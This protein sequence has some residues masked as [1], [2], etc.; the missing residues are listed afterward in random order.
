MFVSLSRLPCATFLV[1]SLPI[2]VA[3]AALAQ[4]PGPG[5]PAG[6]SLP[7]ITVSTVAPRQMRD[8]VIVSGIVA[9]VEEVRVQ[10]LIEGQPIETLLADV[11]DRV[12]AGQVLARLSRSSLELERSQLM[13]SLASA[14]ATIAQNEAQQIEAGASA[15]EAKRVEERTSALREQGAS[16]QAAADQAHSNATATAARVTVAAQ[17]LAAA[18]AQMKLVEAQ[19]GNIELQLSR[20]EVKA[21]V[22]GEIAERNAMIGAVASANA[23]PMFVLIRDSALELRADVAEMDLIR[24]APGQGARVTSIAASTPLSG[25]VRLVEP[26]INLSSHLGRARISIKEAGAIRSGMF[27]DAEILISQRKALAVPISA[28]GAQGQGAAVM[29]VDGGKVRQRLVETGI[30]DNGWVEIRRGLQAG[31]TVVTKAGA[32]VQEGDLVHP[33]PATDDAAERTPEIHSTPEIRSTT[34]ADRMTAT[35]SPFP[36]PA[37][38][39][40]ASAAPPPAKLN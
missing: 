10:P 30:R 5:F 14:K 25:R 37:P 23:S 19:I 21:P 8:R 35:P 15:E 40:S 4:S 31:E 38:S 24:L 33:V 22:T 17:S 7:A 27:A 34:K 9:P 36:S 12:E 20:T 2:C 28:V 11:G 3:P 16:S 29:V 13:A 1:F 26:T 32:F 6:A 39:G 18:R